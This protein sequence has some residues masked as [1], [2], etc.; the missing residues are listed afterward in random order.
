MKT[1]IFTLSLLFC[2]F[3]SAQELDLVVPV[4]HTGTVL[5]VAVSPDQKFVASIDDGFDIVIWD[6]A[7]AKQLFSLKGHQ[8]VINDIDFI[9]DTRLI[10]GSS[11]GFVRI[12]DVSKNESISTIEVGEPVIQVE[13]SNGGIYVLT[14]SKIRLHST[15]NAEM[16]GEQALN[17]RASALM[18]SENAILVGT[19]EGNVTTLTPDLNPGISS[20]ISNV[21]ISSVKKHG[22]N[23]YFGSD[24]GELI[25]ADL[26]LTTLA[27]YNPMSLRVYDFEIYTPTE[28]IFVVGRDD[29][30]AA[31]V[32]NLNTGEVV[33]EIFKAGHFKID[34]YALGSWTVE[35]TS[36]DSSI[37]IASPDYTIAEYK[38]PEQERIRTF[39]GTAH[40]ISTIEL[41]NRDQLVLGSSVG[42]LKEIDLKGVGSIQSYNW[43]ENG[44]RSV[45][46]HPVQPKMVSVGDDNYIRVS[47]DEVLKSYKTNA[48]YLSTPVTFDPLGR[49][50]IRKSDD[51][52]FDVYDLEGGDH[53]KLKV[54]D[55]FGHRFSP[56]GEKI[57]VRTRDGISVFETQTLKQEAEISIK[58]AQDFDVKS[59][60]IVVL[61]R[62][63][64]TLVEYTFAGKRKGTQVIEGLRADQIRISPDG[65][66][67]YTFTNSVAKGETTRD[68]SLTKVDLTSGEIA[69]KL[70]G[71]SG[72]ISS[73]N[74][75]D[76]GEF[77]FTSSVDGKINIYPAI[78]NS[79]PAATIISLG[80][81]D[82][83]VVTPDGLYDATQDAM[84]SL[85]YVRGGDILSLDQFKNGFYE[86]NLLPRLLGLIDDPLPNRSIG[87]VLPHPEMSIKHP[88]LNDGILGISVEDNG[89]G[90]GEIVI[91]INGKEVSRDARDVSTSAEG[92]V[93]F[94]YQ[95]SGHPYLRGDGID[96]VIIKAYNKDGT[97]STAEKSISVFPESKLTKKE[98]KL[99]A[100]IAGT[101]DYGGEALDLQFAAKDAEDFAEALRKSANNQFG[102]ENVRITVLTTN[103]KDQSRWPFKQNLDSVFTAFGKEAN[104]L[105]HL[106]IYLAGHGVNDGDFYYLTAKADDAVL[107]EEDKSEIA[108]SSQE[109]TDWIKRV[110]AL[111][112][113]MI[114]DACH[115]GR[116]ANELLQYSSTTTMEVDRIKAMERMKDRT[117]LYV[118]AGSKADA[119]SYEASLFE[120]GLLTYSILFGMKGAAL[121]SDEN[122]DVMD[123]FQFVQRKVPELAADIGGIQKPEVRYP[124]NAESFS[125]GKLTDTD[126]E[127]IAIVQPKPVFIHSGFQGQQDFHDVL[128][129][130]EFVD[131]QLV[132]NDSE[133]GKIVFL[134]KP[135]FTGAHTIR[136][137]YTV[138]G[139]SIRVNVK[140]Y[141]DSEVMTEFTVNGVS[142]EAVAQEISTRILDLF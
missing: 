133:S 27:T 48:R 59:D 26:E 74:F 40:P 141:R 11:D 75:Y 4:G 68:Y 110:P 135:N 19:W 94:D 46:Y 112:Q 122:V 23:L 2:L 115:S 30:S 6:H 103:D 21:R 60:G 83:V 31:K 45:A 34:Q 73:V 66:T 120:Q 10:S 84:K 43:A 36:D 102:E 97:L 129:M 18:I 25:K 55:G 38:L 108:I 109:L 130:G 101:S 113:V 52:F 118:L 105:D 81:E 28:R 5:D 106:V 104:A 64:K 117:G 20:Q 62:D 76:R 39:R 77:I 37:F 91:I 32:L 111:Q 138:S 139:S 44:I 119:V 124:A 127:A 70:T 93:E 90:I 72:F 99:F 42:I 14:E 13:H 98:P 80:K 123:L 88:N 8:Q 7:R 17:G 56:D 50:I 22:E 53:K 16:L 54:N 71:H 49:Y 87:Q 78:S 125:L 89:G 82:M 95:I 132:S 121:Q 114:L 69:G 96:R 35:L 131:K 136:G 85:H 126:K 57:F 65:M 24:A 15:D 92:S 107:N 33:D 1:F 63:D 58:D 12:W 9:D 51:K 142:P 41:S 3:L 100:V 61:L 29:Q 79:K 137:R 47:N 128:R 67:A 134:D 116:F 86:P 140:L